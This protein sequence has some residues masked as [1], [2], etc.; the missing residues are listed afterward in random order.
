MSAAAISN[1]PTRLLYPLYRV[2]NLLINTE[3]IIFGF[4]QHG[5]GGKKMLYAVHCGQRKWFNRTVQTVEQNGERRGIGE[6]G[7]HGKTAA[8]GVG[9]NPAEGAPSGLFAAY[10][11]SHWLKQELWHTLCRKNMVDVT[12]FPGRP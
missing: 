9:S 3:E 11:L 6:T 7:K 12:G 4:L 5:G 10:F 8:E 1:P 2:L